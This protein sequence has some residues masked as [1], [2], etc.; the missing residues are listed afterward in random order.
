[1]AVDVSQISQCRVLLHVGFHKTAT[2]FLQ[3]KVF[4]DLDLNYVSILDLQDKLNELLYQDLFNFRASQ[5][6]SFFADKFQTSQLNLI[7]EEKLSGQP[8][9]GYLNNSIVL[10]KLQAIFPQARILIVLRRQAD[11]LVSMYKQHIK[12]GG[13]YS[14]E[15]YFSLKGSVSG[16][17]YNI[18]RKCLNIEVF[19]FSEFIKA[20]Q[21]AFG[22]ENVDVVFYEEIF[23]TSALS[24]IF[25]RNGIEFSLKSYT[26]EKR[27]NMA[28]NQRQLWIAAKLNRYL[29]S[30]HNPNPL[31]PAFRIP[32]IGTINVV[33][34]RKVLQTQ[35]I[36]WFQK[37][38]PF[39]FS[40]QVKRH[41]VEF[42][43]DDNLALQELIGRELPPGY[44]K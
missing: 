35:K 40:D 3:K 42:F 32:R 28:Y 7:S 31:I 6:Q 44:L 25:K 43:Q 23:K 22:K 24:D 21:Q 27:V 8:S 16:T 17:D 30:Q 20:Y 2:T 9:I 14:P 13:W 37:S 10:Q 39:V 26:S 38:E 12:E 4:P 1:M 18:Y 34:L 15:E 11:L 29:G 36:K 5:W 19:K 33:K 41:V